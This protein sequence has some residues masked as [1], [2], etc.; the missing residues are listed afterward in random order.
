MGR[1]VRGSPALGETVMAV[2]TA[3]HNLVLVDRSSGELLWRSHLDASVRAGPLLDEDRLYVATE[4]QPQGR[5]YAIRL[6]DGRRLW[7]R[8]RL[9]LRLRYGVPGGRRAR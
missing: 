1:G 6:R 9:G 4:S 7:L 8:P 3:D 5:V 2:G